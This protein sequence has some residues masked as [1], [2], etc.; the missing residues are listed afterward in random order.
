MKKEIVNPETG[1]WAEHDVAY[2][3]A[4]VVHMP[5][6]K[7]MFIS[8]VAAEGDDIETQT[9]ATLEKIEDML[10]EFGGGMEDVV[11]VR[12]YIN[13]PEMDEDSL[14]T[15]HGVRSEFFVQEHLP[16]STLIEV[17]DLVSD[18]F[19]IEID[20]DAVIPDDGWETEHV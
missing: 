6:A 14:E 3:D 15:V 9:Q 17:E 4:V 18:E 13:R 20:A 2:S 16:A 12:V 5:D 11:R 8:G 10:S 7:R 19:L 1:E